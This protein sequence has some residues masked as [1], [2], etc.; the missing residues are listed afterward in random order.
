MHNGNDK[1]SLHHLLRR[2]LA[3]LAFVDLAGSE[4]AWRTRNTG[5]QLRESSAINSSLMMLW[6]CLEGLRYNQWLE[7]M[8]RKHKQL[9]PGAAPIRL[10]YREYAVSSPTKSALQQ[11]PSLRHG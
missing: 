1:L 8:R 4:R 9:P 11:T 7:V 6:R 3:R 10:P 2:P 5:A